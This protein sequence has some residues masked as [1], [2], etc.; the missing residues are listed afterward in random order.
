[1]N[2]IKIIYK[3]TNEDKIR[4]FGDVFVENN[5]NNCFLMINGKKEKLCTHIDTKDIKDER[6]NIELIEEK[7]IS[8]MSHMFNECKLLLSLPNISYFKLEYEK[9]N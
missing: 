6:F 5:F 4:I 9:C 1:M 7:I 2:K 8:D 3:T